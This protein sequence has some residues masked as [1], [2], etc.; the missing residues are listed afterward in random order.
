[1]GIEALTRSVARNSAHDEARHALL[2]ATLD[3][4]QAEEAFKQAKEWQAS[5]DSDPELSYRDLAL[6]ALASGKIKEAEAAVGRALKLKGAEAETH[7]IRAMIAFAQGDGKAAFSALERANKLA[8]TDAETFCEIGHAFQRQGQ[9]DKAL[10]AYQAALREAPNS[11]CGAAGAVMARLPGGARPAV[12]EMA[13]LLP[14]AQRAWDRAWVLTAKSRALL[15]SNAL[16]ESRA[17]AEEAVKQAPALAAGHLALGLVA[18]KQKDDSTAR[19]ALARAVTLDPLSG[20]ARLGM[21]D[22]LFRS[23]AAELPR[24]AEQ[25]QAFLKIGGS[26]SD[27]ARVKRLLQGLKKRLAAR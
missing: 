5:E 9:G 18:L 27:E 4:G 26:S 6:A 22:A 11:V 2:R 21:A 14:K 8:P 24:A 19:E 12:K 23:G 10:K 20:G 3:A 15:S 25:Y 16:K 17:T 1:A 13:A 7:R